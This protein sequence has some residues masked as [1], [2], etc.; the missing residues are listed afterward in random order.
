MTIGVD[1]LI[2]EDNEPRVIGHVMRFGS[3]AEV[4]EACRCGEEDNEERLYVEGE[5]VVG[6]L[7]HARVT[8]RLAENSAVGELLEVD[9]DAR[10]GR[11]DYG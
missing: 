9:S 10:V 6:F 8:E 2:G 11:V 1:S 4:L 5:I 7:L 3:R